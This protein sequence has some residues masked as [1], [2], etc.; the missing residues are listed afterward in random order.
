VRPGHFYISPDRGLNWG[1]RPNERTHWELFR[2][3]ALDFT[4]T[5]EQRS[6]KSWNVWDGPTPGEPLVSVKFDVSAGQIHLTRSILCRAVEAYTGD[7]GTI[8]TREANRP[9]RELVGT[10]DLSRL[11][12][13]SELHDELVSL[14]FAAVVGVSR[15][16]LTSLEMPLPAFTLGQFAYCYQPDAQDIASTS[17]SDWISRSLRCNLAKAEASRMLEF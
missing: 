8:M 2:G 6:F 3:R 11:A 7:N 4:Q 10:I 15:L 9:V 17:P 13:G 5:R 14:I 16:P 1:F 12:S